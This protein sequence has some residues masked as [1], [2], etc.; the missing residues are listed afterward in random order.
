[1]LRKGLIAL[2]FL[3]GI[4]CIIGWAFEIPRIDG[5][6]DVGLLIVRAA[7]IGAG[8]GFVLGVV[9]SLSSKTF[10]GRFQAVATSVILCTVGGPLLGHYTNRA[11]S[12]EDVQ[13]MDLPVKQ[14]TSE[15]SGRGV[16]RDALEAGPNAYSIYVE[17]EDGLVRLRQQG[18]EAPE[19]GP[20]RTLPVLR[21][22]GYWGYPLYALAEAPA[23]PAEQTFD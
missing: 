11:F 18:G 16:S 6:I 10:I 4:G 12:R 3:I 21:N 23:A 7:T 9:I 2:A 19:I 1:M 15:F 17:T 5:T 22:P 8:V 13:I 20:S 14:V